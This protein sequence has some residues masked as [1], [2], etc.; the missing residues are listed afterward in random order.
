MGFVLTELH[1]RDFRNHTVFDLCQPVGDIII[2]GP[3]A[4]GK[5]S[6]LEAVQLLTI[7][8]SFR[9]SNWQD[10]VREGAEQSRISG[11]FSDAGRVLDV[12]LTI[13]NGKR[14]YLFNGKK[15]RLSEFS[16]NIPTILFTPDDLN[17]V[18]GPAEQRRLCL[19]DL[20]KRLSKQ[21]YQ[22]Y[23]DYQKTL[24]QRNSIL[25][26]QQ[27]KRYLGSLPSQ[28]E[29]AWD[30]R[31]A[32]LGA[33]LTTHRYRLYQ[34]LMEKAIQHYQQLAVSEQLSAAYIPSYHWPD[35]TALLSLPTKTEVQEQLLQLID[36]RRQEE[37]NRGTS[38]VGPH[39]DELCFFINGQEA[40]GFV[41]QG[42][43]R[44]IALAVKIAELD[45]LKEISGGEAI[46]L[47]DDVLSELDKDRRE[48]LLNLCQEVSQSFITTTDISSL[49]EQYYQTGTLIELGAPD[50]VHPG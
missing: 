28:A 9:T 33:L 41:S 37:Y 40:R 26:E 44:S 30:T 36:V 23:T 2:V 5:S 12:E 7:L 4:I 34:R 13:N 31:L 27:K 15:R 48:R 38:L 1:L 11:R 18:K 8:Q 22:I 50:A 35:K 42:Q 25:R 6:I 16:E 17:L 43:Q 3:N 49:P 20:G 14:E 46:L 32:E 21:Y 19:D 45:M 39:R 24:R 47:L 29:L 10:L